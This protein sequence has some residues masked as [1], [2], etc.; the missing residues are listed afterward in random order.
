MINAL[1]D[2][3]VVIASASALQLKSS[4]TA[5]ISVLTIGELHAGVRLAKTSDVRAQRQ[6]RLAA[7][8]AAFEPV[9]VDEL[10]AERYGELLALARSERRATKATDLLILAT[11]ATSGRT[12]VTLDEAQ[13]AL[14][15]SAGLM[16][17]P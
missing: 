9:P 15:R 12:L 1:L 11:A 7:V 6:A 4:D 5:A 13:A 17:N 14:A 16:V 3:S 8:R 2:T 10:I